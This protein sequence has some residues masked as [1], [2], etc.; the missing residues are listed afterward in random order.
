MKT[1][2]G[3]TTRGGS[4]GSSGK[5]STR[6][7]PRQPFP[8]SGAVPPAPASFGVAVT[9]ITTAGMHAPMDRQYRLDMTGETW[10]GVAYRDLDV[11]WD[12]DEDYT[13]TAL[14]D[15]PSDIQCGDRKAGKYVGLTSRHVYTTPGTYTPT[16][17]IRHRNGSSTVI[18]LAPVIVGD[19][20]TVFPG[21]STI[22]VS[23]DADFTGAPFG[24]LQVTV[25]N[26]NI[27]GQS[28]NTRANLV[29]VRVMF[30]RGQS[31]TG[32]GDSRLPNVLVAAFG[33]GAR[34]NISTGFNFQPMPGA[35]TQDGP[36]AIKL[37]GVA[38][39]TGYDPAAANDWQNENPAPTSPPGIS[40]GG[41]AGPVVADCEFRGIFSL[42]MSKNGPQLRGVAF[43]TIVRD[44]F[45]F[46][47]LGTGGWIG[48]A[49]YQPTNISALSMSWSGNAIPP[50]RNTWNTTYLPGHPLEGQAV[51][52]W[53]RHTPWRLN[54]RD[55]VVAHKTYFLGGGG[56]SGF[57]QP[58]LRYA[59]NGAGTRDGG[60]AED[61]ATFSECHF[62]GGFSVI[63]TG[64]TNSEIGP[65]VDARCVLFESCTVK[66]FLDTWRIVDA[67]F[68][69][70][71]FRNCLFIA[72]E[73][74]S[75]QVQNV[76]Y[77]A[78]PRNST[79]ISTGSP[80]RFV[81]GTAIVETLQGSKQI[82]LANTIFGTNGLPTCEFHN[83][84]TFATD[85]SRVVGEWTQTPLTDLSANFTPLVGT[86]NYE[87]ATGVVPVR[88]YAGATRAAS[89]NRGYR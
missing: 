56:W 83:M 43:N 7:T 42:T 6:Q 68:G 61:V 36:G 15:V 32:W 70:I 22:C 25:A 77:L 73:G 12:F 38:V 35:D 57:H 13:F 20:N 60:T 37:H 51:P 33:T 14:A 79:G 55:N 72:P 48:C 47:A 10:G 66:S 19:P 85:I 86:D 58:C 9:S 44:W 87:A 53:P 76:F 30:K 1:R 11:V 39:I 41:C 52:N 2:S 88:N 4:G 46:G 71:E 23:R 62:E 16:C 5:A 74:T 28:W 63:E 21:T 45:D 78:T 64:V 26:G 82:R 69:G 18:T 31:F 67:S 17:T 29:N 3:A 24:A 80:V 54:G 34:P 40:F 84:V 89:A 8:A 65:P 49:V 27:T 75:T 81:N 50:N 59:T